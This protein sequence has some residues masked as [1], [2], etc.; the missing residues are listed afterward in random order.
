MSQS[1]QAGPQP[2]AAQQPDAGRG[3]ERGIETAR[4]EQ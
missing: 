3:Q 2:G 1:A 4:I